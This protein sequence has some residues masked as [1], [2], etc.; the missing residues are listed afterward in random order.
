ME[1]VSLTINGEPISVPAQTTVLDAAALLGIRIPT[2]CHDP[3]LSSIG[4]CRLCQVEVVGRGLIPACSTAVTAGIKV[5]THSEEV[6]TARRT[7]VQLLLANHPESCLVCDKGNRCRLRKVAADLGV[8]PLRYYPMPQFDALPDP[9]PFIKRD[10]SKCILCGQCIR[11]DQELV[12]EGVLD[13]IHRG[14]P[15]RPATVGNLPLYEAGCSFCGTCMTFCPTGALTEAGRPHVGSVA[16][17]VPGVCGYCGCGC[18]IGVE[19]SEEHVVGVVPDR[20]SSEGGATLCVRGHFGY[21]YLDHPD[22]LVSPL[23]RKDGELTE[24]DWSE[25][26]AAAADKLGQGRG[27]A[28]VI[29]GAQSPLEAHYLLARLARQALGSP[30]IDNTASMAM[31]PAGN[32]L[33]ARLGRKW[34]T[35]PL[36]QIEQASA[37]VVVGADLTHTAPVVGYHVK[38]ASMAGIPLVVLDVRETEIATRADIRFEI[39]PGSDAWLLYGL[40]RIITAGKEAA[41]QGLQDFVAGFEPEAVAERTGVGPSDLQA[42]AELLDV[43]GDLCVIVGGGVFGQPG[44]EAAMAACLDLMHLTASMKSTGGGLFLVWADA[45]GPG[46][47]LAG[48]TPAGW[49]GLAEAAAVWT[50]SEPDT[51]AGMSALDMIAAAGNGD[52]KA[53]LVWG[54]DLTGLIPGGAG[55]EAALDK[56]DGLVVADLF[57]TQTANRADVVL[58]LAGVFEQDGRLMS[59]TGRVQSCTAAAL[60]PPEV[61]PEWRQIVRLAEALGAGFSY[62]S[63]DDVWAEMMGLWPDWNKTDHI[64]MPGPNLPGGYVLAASAEPRAAADKKYPFTLVASHLRYSHGDGSRTS[65]ATRLGKMSPAPEAVLSPSDAERLKVASGDEVEV[66]T[67]VGKAFFDVAIDRYLTPG[68]VVVPLAVNGAGSVRLLP[69]PGGGSG[70]GIL[71]R[72]CP[73]EVFRKGGR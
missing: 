35:R 61:E 55:V 38:R 39:T 43:N 58:P 13:Y 34:A 8:G 46:A 48:A 73:A 49:P 2:L 42:A 7:V 1:T 19:I 59:L 22:R 11:A 18:R 60:P 50:G 41:D 51:Q 68:L 72:T 27:L 56:L 57:L 30:H 69:G 24:V 33:A 54:A 31:G 4:A 9:N 21:D 40:A 28:G 32:L 20:E 26:L 25:A 12:C 44:G 64:L 47:E 3:I 65:R 5:A 70:G 71:P 23:V 15:S 6:L 67:A 45:A 37:I 29:A 62:D 10:M 53:L 63:H 52:L 14:F 16:I 36:A 17:E 66:A